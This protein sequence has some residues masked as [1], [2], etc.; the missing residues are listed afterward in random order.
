M[1]GQGSF[2][3]NG[4]SMTRPPYSMTKRHYDVTTTTEP[5]TFV[6]TF[7]RVITTFVTWLSGLIFVL[8]MIR[9]VKEIRSSGLTS[10]ISWLMKM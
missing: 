9:C 3:E 10:F 4:G 2:D 7:G 8:E 5:S 6:M 1:L